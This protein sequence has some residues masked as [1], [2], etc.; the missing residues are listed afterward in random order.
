VRIAVLA[1]ARQPVAR[2]FAGGMEALCWHLVAGLSA[3]GHEVVLFASGDSDPRF[4][5]DPLCA[6]HHERTFPNRE[7]QADPALVAHVDECYAG[8]C[9]RIAAGGFDVLHN[10]SLSRLPLSRALTDR[11]PTLT[12]LHV[13]PYDALRHFV[14]QSQGPGH[15][16]TVTSDAQR[17]LWWPEG[18]PP[19]VS[20]LHN[21]IDPDA[22]PFH[23]TGNGSAVWCG[24]IAPVKGTHLAV[25]AARIAGIPLTLFGPI[26]DQAYWE[27]RVKPYLGGA[28]RYG[29]HRDDRTL[30]GEIGRAGVFLFTPCWDEP[31][32]L[33]AA[34]AMA[35]GLPVA[36]LDRGAAREVVG[37]AGILVGEADAGALAQAMGE[38]L[39]IPRTIPRARVMRLFTRD[40]W[41]DGCEGFYAELRQSAGRTG[42]GSLTPA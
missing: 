26:E 2:P 5:L 20:V 8:A 24:R 34:E 29:G 38:A 35:C 40:R 37:E 3:R 11:V 9:A 25:A 42:R 18:S 12:S 16:L 32:G 7:H 21:G 13:P 31:F 30:A 23:A 33:V 28:I 14:G 36:G 39:A 15:R 6:E 4:T 10:N 22:W 41:L 27:A 19:D 1:H 17:I